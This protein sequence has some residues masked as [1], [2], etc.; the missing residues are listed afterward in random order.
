[1]GGLNAHR[2]KGLIRVS[3][4]CSDCYVL[5]GDDGLVVVELRHDRPGGDFAASRPVTSR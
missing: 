3:R 5:D 2:G 1:M 4:W